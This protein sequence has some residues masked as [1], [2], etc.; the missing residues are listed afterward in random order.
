VTQ[1]LPSGDKYTYSRDFYKIRLAAMMGG[2]AAEELALH[3]MTTGASSDID[4]ASKL[5]Q[6]M[7]CRYGMSDALG[8]LSY[9]KQDEQIFLGREIAQHRDYSEET[10]RLID[11]EVRRLVMDAYEL[12]LALI[13]RHMDTLKALTD[14]LLEKETLEAE[15]VISLCAPAITAEGLEVPQPSPSSSMSSKTKPLPEEEEDEE[16]DEDDEDGGEA[17]SGRQVPPG[18]TRH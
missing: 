13:G 6:N 5:A 18:T 12:A 17:K 11:S 2:R 16:D 7:V 1:Y 15:E 8:P 4:Q 10:A 9:K 14:A 3:Q